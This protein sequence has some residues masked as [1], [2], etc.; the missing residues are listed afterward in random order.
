MTNRAQV[1]QSYNVDFFTTLQPGDR[2]TFTDE[3]TPANFYTVTPDTTG[4]PILIPKEH[5][6]QFFKYY[7]QQT[8][9]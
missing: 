1:E 6:N 3:E 8:I 2:V 7:T 4:N 9:F 5:F